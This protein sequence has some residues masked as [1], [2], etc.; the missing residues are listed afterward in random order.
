MFVLPTCS[1][2]GGLVG[3]APKVTRTRTKQIISVEK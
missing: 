3:N 1:T 2:S